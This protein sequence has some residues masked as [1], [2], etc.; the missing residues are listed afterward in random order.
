MRRRTL[1]GAK[2]RASAVLGIIL[3]SCSMA[4]SQAPSDPLKS[5]FE[6]PPQSARP[7]VWRRWV[8]G[9]V[10]REGIRLDI[11]WMHRVG[12]GGFQTV[13]VGVFAPPLVPKQVIF[14]SPEWKSAVVA[15][16]RQAIGYGMSVGVGGAPGWSESGGPWVEP[17]EAM[18]KY[19][20]SELTVEGGKPISGKLPH[21]PMQ[22]GLFQSLGLHDDL[23]G[24]RQAVP[25]YYQDV[26]VVAYRVPA[27][28][29]G[30]RPQPVIAFT[31]TTLDPDKLSD[32]D[33]EKTTQLSL[34]NPAS[35]YCELRG[36]RGRPLMGRRL[37][38]LTGRANG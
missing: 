30:A 8:N 33:L 26:K 17:S 14:Q 15:A 36:G 3:I 38:T 21:P 10:T 29:A 16:A 19:V 35:G 31:G 1:W 37:S 23:G 22:T 5:A 4:H 2:A 20:W 32:G 11:D 25:Q 7:R 18:K 9:N 24:V 28:Y 34:R 6:N 13:E 27:K 12:L